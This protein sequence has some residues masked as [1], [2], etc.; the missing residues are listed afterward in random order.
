MYTHIGNDHVA[1]R[2]R[3]HEFTG[4]HP[5]LA[6]EIFKEFNSVQSDK[7]HEEFCKW[8]E[9]IQEGKKW[10]SPTEMTVF[11]YC[12]GIHVVLV[13]QLFPRVVTMY[14]YGIERLKRFRMTKHEI[15][16]FQDKPKNPRDVIIIWHH[17]ISQPTNFVGKKNGPTDTKYYNH[18]SLLIPTDRSDI[19]PEV[20]FFIKMMKQRISMSIWLWMIRLMIPKNN[21]KSHLI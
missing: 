8:R 5:T 11:A 1:V 16:S 3:L 2:K 4:L 18:F 14:T 17:N 6:K 20:I 10:G 21:L 12:Y 7:L 13:S 15:T 19:N 9:T